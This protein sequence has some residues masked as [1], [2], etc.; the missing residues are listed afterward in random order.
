MGVPNAARKTLFL[1]Y[2]AVTLASV[3]HAV[4]PEKGA[5]ALPWHPCYASQFAAVAVNWEALFF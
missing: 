3:Q 4:D 1:V 5:D 2:T